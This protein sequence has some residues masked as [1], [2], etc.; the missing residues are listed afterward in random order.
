MF[1]QPK[2]EGKGEIHRVDV[3]KLELRYEQTWGDRGFLLLWG[4]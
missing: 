1:A 2:A 4:F 3:V